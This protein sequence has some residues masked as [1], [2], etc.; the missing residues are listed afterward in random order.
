MIANPYAG[1]RIV[2]QAEVQTSLRGCLYFAFGERES[3]QF[4]Q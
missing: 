4:V 3:K 2:W 1:V